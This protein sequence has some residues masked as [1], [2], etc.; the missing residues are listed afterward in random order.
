MIEKS[1]NKNKYY[2][3]LKFIRNKHGLI[4]KIFNKQRHKSIER[5]HPHPA[6]TF[7]ELKK[8]I[9]SQKLFHSLFE[10]WEQSN[11][12]SDLIPSVDRIND[13]DYYHFDN[14]QLM[15]WAEN[16]GKR[17]KKINQFSKDGI[18]INTFKSVTKASKELKI[19]RTAISSCLIGNT[20]SSGGFVWKYFTDSKF[21]GYISKRN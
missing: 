21:S 18:L 16:R 17:S 9:M 1:N 4:V 10:T 7:L 6:Y 13:E 3:R 19:S 12:F 20:K 14:I 11:Y 5:G 15:T 2:C 8:W